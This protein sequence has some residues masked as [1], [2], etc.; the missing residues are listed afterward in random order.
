M[1]PAQAMDELERVLKQAGLERWMSCF[2]PP[3]FVSGQNQQ[4]ES[5]E[6]G[7]VKEDD[8]TRTD[9]QPTTAATTNTNSGDEVEVEDEQDQ[10]VNSTDDDTDSCASHDW[11]VQRVCKIKPGRY[12]VYW[13]GCAKATIED[14]SISEGC[15]QLKR[16]A[17]IWYSRHQYPVDLI[18]S[19][20][21]NGGP[22]T[23]AHHEF[24]VCTEKHEHGFGARTGYYCL[25]AKKT[26][27]IPAKDVSLEC[28][29]AYHYATYPIMRSPHPNINEE[30]A[31]CGICGL[32]RGDAFAHPYLK[33]EDICYTCL[34][35]LHQKRKQTKPWCKRCGYD[36]NSDDA[37]HERMMSG[38]GTSAVACDWC[39]KY[40]P[41]LWEE[42][43]VRELRT[44]T[45][46]FLFENV[47]SMS[48]D[49]KR[50]IS[51]T[52]GVKPVTHDAK[53]ITAINKKRYFWSNIDR[54][55]E[56]LP[57]LK[58]DLQSCLPTGHFAI[59]PKGHVPVTRMAPLDKQVAGN[60]VKLTVTDIL[61]GWRMP[62]DLFANVEIPSSD[63]R[64]MLANCFVPGVIQ[65]ILRPFKGKKLVIISLFSGVEMSL[66]GAKDAGVEV[67]GFYSAEINVKCDKV[68]SH[69]QHG[70]PITRLGDVTKIQPYHLAAIRA[71]HY[72]HQ[73]LLIGGSPCQDL[74][75]A[76]PERK[77]LLDATGKSEIFFHFPRIQRELERIINTNVAETM[78]VTP[79]SAKTIKQQIGASM[80]R[81]TKRKK[82]TARKS[83]RRPAP[84]SVS[85]SEDEE[86]DDDDVS[87]IDVTPAG[88]KRKRV[89]LDGNPL[90]WEPL[91]K[92][93]TTPLTTMTTT[94]TT[95]TSTTTSTTNTTTTMECDERADDADDEQTA[96]KDE[97]EETE[98]DNDD[99]NDDD[100]GDAHSSS[101]SA[102]SQQVQDTSSAT[103]EQPRLALPKAPRKL[104]HKTLKRSKKEKATARKSCGGAVAQRYL[105]E[106]EQTKVSSSSET[107]EDS[108]S[109]GLEIVEC[110][111]PTRA[112]QVQTGVRRR[113]GSWT[114]S[115]GQYV[116]SQ[117]RKE[118]CA[119]CNKKLDCLPCQNCQ[120][121]VHYPLFT[122]R[123]TRSTNKLVEQATDCGLQFRGQYLCCQCI[124]KQPLK[125]EEEQ[126]VDDD[127]D[128][129]QLS[130]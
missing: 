73:C 54:I 91:K 36:I 106:M 82:P 102:Q 66:I 104:S 89:A 123:S 15:D 33:G 8:D 18:W 74:S 52:F 94:T 119:V 3:Q 10:Q 115:E 96:M 45:I 109:D 71:R 6:D 29:H 41:E 2:N 17:D 83:T 65:H 31:Q 68:N 48:E 124:A 110:R 51:A 118:I 19:T 24:L 14:E 72:P 112:P 84:L 28:R 100:E 101:S 61:K 76:N 111:P 87:I 98:E 42:P 7:A 64:R 130:P 40:G 21:A 5:A 53:S 26:K 99:D 20:K 39:A 116:Q 23:T 117:L 38:S 44:D 9:V 103:S 90:D 22:I 126:A 120:R 25:G 43:D 63:Q 81:K 50:F 85:S 4:Q 92:P 113:F 67:V 56:P 62:L 12:R 127:S 125:K 11:E 121:W 59:A 32:L 75:S 80:G 55:H 1:E 13:V 95:T 128:I 49:A 70:V 97:Q 78:M 35:L 86:D 34:E 30:V 69:Y 114:S 107:N 46:W 37:R 60:H 129:V 27:A 47:A 108:S 16:A 122:T 58:I 105:N 57:Q 93:D 77:G 88:L 79:L